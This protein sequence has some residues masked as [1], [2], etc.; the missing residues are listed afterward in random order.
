MC[1]V[2]TTTESLLD[3][4]TPRS[5]PPSAQ[6]LRLRETAVCELKLP[7]YAMA[8][9]GVEVHAITQ[10]PLFCISCWLPHLQR[11]PVGPRFYVVRYFFE[12]IHTM[13]LAV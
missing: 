4:A 11:W 10:L 12:G 2:S 5:E 1:S 7:V 8:I 13:A 9:S 3:E 6:G